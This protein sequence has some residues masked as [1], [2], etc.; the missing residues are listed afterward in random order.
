MESHTK[1]D[2]LAENTFAK[3]LKKS[4]A[5]TESQRTNLERRNFHGNEQYNTPTFYEDMT[6]SGE[7]PEWIT[8]NNAAGLQHDLANNKIPLDEVSVGLELEYQ[9]AYAYNKD[10][11]WFFLTI[12]LSRWTMFRN[13]FLERHA[14][15]VHFLPYWCLCSAGVEHHRHMIFVCRTCDRFHVIED[16]P[17]AT[18]YEASELSPV[19]AFQYLVV[20]IIAENVINETKGLEL[21][22]AIEYVCSHKAICPLEQLSADVKLSCSPHGSKFQSCNPKHHY[23]IAQPIATY[24]NLI[25]ALTIPQGMHI[26]LNSLCDITNPVIIPSLE[27]EMDC[28][29]NQQRWVV[30]AS[31][32]V[33][34]I[35]QLEQFCYPFERNYEYGHQYTLES[36]KQLNEEEPAIKAFLVVGDYVTDVIRN[37][38][39]KNMDEEQWNTHQLETARK[40]KSFF[41][42]IYNMKMVLDLKWQKYLNKYASLCVK[43]ANQINIVQLPDKE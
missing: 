15:R 43:H 5:L 34:D 19:P 3:I 14:E 16:L 42:N 40:R 36:F 17:Y 31:D 22:N 41:S 13:F 29:T 39:L 8:Q 26:Y 32:V 10:L 30:C 9:I 37:D 6:E 24:S 38:S 12:P 21:I 2:V 35:D 27:L 18:R 33:P 23:Y 20:E 25:A 28:R 7:K 1:F 4:H 11:S